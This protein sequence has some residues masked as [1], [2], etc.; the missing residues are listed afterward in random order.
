MRLKQPEST[1]ES[2]FWAFLKSPKLVILAFWLHIQWF[3]LLLFLQRQE[4]STH[5]DDFGNDKT[6][7]VEDD[8]RRFVRLCSLLSGLCHSILLT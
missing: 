6:S 2:L 5:A 3:V 1:K 7:L 4:S 8:R